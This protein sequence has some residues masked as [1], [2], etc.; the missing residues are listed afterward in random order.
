MAKL[1]DEERQQ[2][3]GGNDHVAVQGQRLGK[4]AVE[5]SCQGPSAAAS[6]AGSK[7]KKFSPQA[8]T[9][10]ARQA[11]GRE[12]AKTGQREKQAGQSKDS[13]RRNR[14]DYF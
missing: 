11:L 6:G 14:H 13:A 12:E 7:V 9:E 4:P 1:G 10:A 2:S 5:K 3:R 8:E